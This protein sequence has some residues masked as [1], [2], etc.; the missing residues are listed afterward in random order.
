MIN[1]E[2]DPGNDNTLRFGDSVVNFYRKDVSCVQA[3]VEAD[4]SCV[5]ASV[6]A[7]DLCAYIATAAP[8]KQQKDENDSK[9]SRI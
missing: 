5:Q 3:S 6:E 8:A 1:N 4:V 2:I 7:G 9:S